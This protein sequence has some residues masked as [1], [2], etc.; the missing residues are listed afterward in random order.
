[1]GYSWALASSATRPKP[2]PAAKPKVEAPLKKPETPAAKPLAASDTNKPAAASS[3]SSSGGFK[4]N[5]SPAPSASKPAD[6]N[7]SQVRVDEAEELGG[8]HRKLTKAERKAMKREK[9]NRGDWDEE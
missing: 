7:K 5:V 6:A 4:P 9:Q 8:T 3:S 1:M 2:V